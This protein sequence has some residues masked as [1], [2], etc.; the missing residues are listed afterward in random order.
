MTGNDILERF[1]RS[2]EAR[3][4]NSIF[5]VLQVDPASSPSVRRLFPHIGTLRYYESPRDIPISTIGLYL[6]WALPTVDNDRD[7]L[8][9]VGS[10]RSCIRRTILRME[11][12]FPNPVIGI[13]EFPRS[14]MH[15]ADVLAKLFNTMFV[16][17][18]KG[19]SNIKAAPMLHALSIDWEATTMRFWS[20]V[21]VPGGGSAPTDCTSDVCCEWTAGTQGSYGVFYV[22]AES[23]ELAHRMAYKITRGGIPENSQIRRTCGNTLCCNPLHLY[24]AG[25]S[26]PHVPPL[27]DRL[28][29]RKEMLSE[30]RALRLSLESEVVFAKQN[31]NDVLVLLNGDG[32]PVED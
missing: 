6:V 30:N 14:E 10:S 8:A 2:Q 31:T 7:S 22:S 21:N 32:I 11:H 17:W 15:L 28:K 20:K 13:V 3:S 19:K 12:R 23:K 9:I 4:V 25:A 26:E 29:S 27:E 24:L 18:A 16:P 5:G 1:R